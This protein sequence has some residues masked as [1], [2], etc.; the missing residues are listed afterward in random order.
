MNQCNWVVR[1]RRLSFKDWLLLLEA[2]R[3]LVQACIVIR[4]VPFKYTAAWLNKHSIPKK[5]ES[6]AD[7]IDLIT[8]RISWAIEAVS[9]RGLQNSTCLMR[10]IAGYWMLKRRYILGVISFGVYKNADGE[11]LAHAWLEYDNHIITGKNGYEV[12]TLIERF[13]RGRSF[14]FRT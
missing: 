6:N 4:I 8:K 5:E 14:E 12:Y 9:R 7:V 1:A 13:G 2:M 3:F 10:A 11:L